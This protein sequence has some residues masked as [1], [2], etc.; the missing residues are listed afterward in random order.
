MTKEL[1][2]ELHC[3]YIDTL[4]AQT[5]KH[6]TIQILRNMMLLIQ[7]HHLCFR[8]CVLSKAIPTANNIMAA[9]PYQ[10]RWDGV[11]AKVAILLAS[12]QTYAERAS[13]LCAERAAH[14]QHN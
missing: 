5:V 9:Y 8:R 4:S 7:M 13:Q 10:M 14:L 1:A 3:A 11:F 2:T 12:A 6:C